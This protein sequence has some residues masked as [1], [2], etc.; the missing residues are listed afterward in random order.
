MRC[1]WRSGVDGG[2]WGDITGSPGAR[3]IAPPLRGKVGFRTSPY[4][5]VSGG[6]R[7]GGDGHP[8]PGGGAYGW[9]WLSGRRGGGRG[10]RTGRS[11]VPAPGPPWRV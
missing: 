11:G 7:R 10:G 1:V 3:V 5:S 6:A 2:H 4:W 8:R 9:E